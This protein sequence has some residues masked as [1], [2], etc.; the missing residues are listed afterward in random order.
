MRYSKPGGQPKNKKAGRVMLYVQKRLEPTN[1]ALHM[2][3]G[4]EN[5]N[6]MCVF[7]LTF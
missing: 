3:W 7:S 4:I 5:R 1:R 2:F 6:K